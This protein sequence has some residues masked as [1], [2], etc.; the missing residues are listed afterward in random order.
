[1][2][3][4]AS[5]DDEL[6]DIAHALHA[7]RRDEFVAARNER[8]RELRAAGS[9]D[10]ADAVKGLAKPTQVAWA[11]NAAVRAQEAAARELVDLVRAPGGGNGGR[12]RTTAFETLVQQLLAAAKE[13]LTDAGAAPSPT[14][15]SQVATA[16]RAA[17]L[18]Q[19]VDAF[20]GARLEREPAPGDSLE[21]ALL[22][23]AGD[24]PRRGAAK[25]S[26]ARASAK[27]TA[28]ARATS[29]RTESR[30]RLRRELAAAKEQARA[31][32]AA[33]RDAERELRRLE[34]ALDEAR[35][36]HAAAS[37]D[38]ERARALVDD[39]EASIAELD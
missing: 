38:D 3:T 12:A 32:A 17:P 22:A 19:H 1:M 30:R 5:T 31:A 6:A 33:L 27:E 15:A 26:T 21:A 34:R 20:L 8:A 25:R 2:A 4:R 28:S 16:L 18:G 10:L 24:A 11:V 9:R 14:L 23:S 29:E 36:A 37:G 39:V 7:L 13:A 35:T